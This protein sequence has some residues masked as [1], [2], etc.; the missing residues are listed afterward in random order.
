M[1]TTRE[2]AIAELDKGHKALDALLAKLNYEAMEEPGTIGGGDWSAK[3]LLGHVAGW[4]EI[5]L[6][7]IDDWREGNPPWIEE[8]FGMSDGVDQLNADNDLHG[9]TLSLDETRLRAGDAHRRLL[10]EITAMSDEEWAARAWYRTE[11][12][13]NLGSLLGSILGGAKRPFGHVFDHLPDLEAFVA[14]PR[15]RPG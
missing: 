14:S 2:E 5:A 8:F 1:P 15:R 10:A 7:A 3:D 9:T 13:K 12:R 6:S 4:E 11:R